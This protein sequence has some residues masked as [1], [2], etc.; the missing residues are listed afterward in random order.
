MNKRTL[1]LLISI[2]LFVIT[3]TLLV[4]GAEILT[5]PLLEKPYFPFGNLLT[6]LGFVAL[7]CIFFFGRKRFYEPLS[8]RDRIFA[9]LFKFVIALSALWIPVS[10]LLAGNLSNSFGNS[11][12]F[13]GSQAAG[14]VFWVYSY[15][16]AA[17]PIVLFLVFLATKLFLIGN[18][19]KEVKNT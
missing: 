17:L 13:Q 5:Y 6:A 3:L 18:I 1:L 15:S 10:Y 14:E 16:L 8:K 4:T 12:S 9:R 19:T 2:I 7:P 11:D